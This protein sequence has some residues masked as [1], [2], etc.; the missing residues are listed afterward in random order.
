MQGRPPSSHR[1]EA[2]AMASRSLECRRCH[3]ANI[4]V[5]MPIGVNGGSR[6]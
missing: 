3:S 4:A 5:L 6:A 2:K 1:Q